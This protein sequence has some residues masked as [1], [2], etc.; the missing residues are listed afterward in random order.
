MSKR[1]CVC[2][3]VK[4]AGEDIMGRVRAWFVKTQIVDDDG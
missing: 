1:A 4:G 3:G 2:A